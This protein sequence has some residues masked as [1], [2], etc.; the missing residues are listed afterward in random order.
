MTSDVQLS[1]AKGVNLQI[2]DSKTITCAELV[3]AGAGTSVTAY[4]KAGLKE[5]PTATLTAAKV[6]VEQG[7][8]LT[9]AEGV[10][11]GSTVSALTVNKNASLTNNGTIAA[12][13]ATTTISVSVETGASLVNGEEGA[14]TGQFSI[15]KNAG[16]IVNNND[17]EITVT[18]GMVGKMEGAF[19]FTK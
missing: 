4:D 18:G 14:V 19:T 1:L 16:Q 6:T 13:N 3:V 7:A 12:T 9:V 2:N 10:T 15:T 8:G 11:V 17:A 5:E